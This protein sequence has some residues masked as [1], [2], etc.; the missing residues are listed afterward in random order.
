MSKLEAAGGTL[1]VVIDRRSDVLVVGLIGELDLAA[2]EVVAGLVA[3]LL[4]QPDR[5]VIFDLAD[6]DFIDTSGACLFAAAVEVVICSGYRCSAVAASP[7]VA[8]EIEFAGVATVAGVQPG[9]LRADERAVAP[10]TTVATKFQCGQR[11]GT[12]EPAGLGALL[13]RDDYHSTG[14]GRQLTARPSWSAQLRLAGRTPVSTH[15]NQRQG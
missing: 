4:R 1:E 9:A 7:A 15:P 3:G 8:R 12:S 10:A 14:F 5:D 2:A 13:D 11:Q 6:L